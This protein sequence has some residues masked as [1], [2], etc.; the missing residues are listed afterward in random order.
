MADDDLHEELHEELRPLLFAIAYRMVG[1]VS[2]A[3]DIVQEAY[4]RFRRATDAGTAIEAPKAYLA[5]VTTRLAVDHLR[6]ARVRRESYVGPWLPEPLVVEPGPEDIVEMADSLST[7]FLV[8]LETLSPIE[9]AVF[10]LRD[11]FGYGYDEIAGIVG[12]TEANCRQILSRARRHIDAGR[13]RF[14]ASPHE[15]DVLARQFMSA[16]DEGDVEGLVRLLADDVTFYSDGGGKA[17]AALRPVHGRDRV[18]R[19]LEGLL[20]RVQELGLVFRPALVNGQPGALVLDPEGK[21]FGVYALDVAEGAVT[22][23]WAVV[24]PEKLRHL[25]PVSDLGRRGSSTS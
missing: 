17:A 25:G 14:T 19:L 1:S 13:P 20:G 2:E 9:R 12:K 15:R 7:A 3:E 21:V 16:C 4:L 8:L 11:V 5:S 10:L 24:N 23:I 18:S 22:T 6:S